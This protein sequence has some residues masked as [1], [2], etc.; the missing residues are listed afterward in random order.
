MHLHNYLVFISLKKISSG[1]YKKTIKNTPNKNSKE[2][3]SV[4]TMEEMLEQKLKSYEKNIKSYLAVKNEL[5]SKRA[6][7]L[8]EK[9]SDLQP[10][11]EQSGEVNLEKF[12]AIDRDASHINET[13]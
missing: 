11:M 3:S 4:I 6:N 2:N 13:F 8:N 12:K 10:S 5:L 9:L 7:E 1:G